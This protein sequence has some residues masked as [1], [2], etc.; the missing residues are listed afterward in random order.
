MPNPNLRCK[1]DDQM[2]ELPI[3]FPEA[4]T[5]AIA[6]QRYEDAASILSDLGHKPS[7]VGM[8]TGP[9]Y[10]G[11]SLCGFV[12]QHGQ[13]QLI[14]DCLLATY[15][16]N[17][18]GRQTREFMSLDKVSKLTVAVLNPALAHGIKCMKEMRAARAAAPAQA[19]ASSE[20]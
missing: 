1:V 8:L 2:V 13:G 5:D 3:S 16:S 20:S 10:N 9:P 7:L 19:E 18:T 15:W 12:I 4:L 17:E 14:L 6:D 11:G